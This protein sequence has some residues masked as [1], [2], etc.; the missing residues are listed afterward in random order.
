MWLLQGWGSET[1]TWPCP[2]VVPSLDTGK[3]SGRGWRRGMLWKDDRRADLT[4]PARDGAPPAE[5]GWEGRRTHAPHGTALPRG[6]ALANLISQFSLAL[7]LFLY[8]FWKKL[9]QATWGGK[10]CLLF[11][12]SDMGFASGE[13]QAT[14]SCV[15]MV[16]VPPQAG[17]WSACRTGAPSSAWPSPACSCCAWSG[18]PTRS[19]AS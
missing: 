11:S 7:L 6:S 9:H 12:N 15:V 5:G 13:L 2:R 4:I 10:G 17:P 3:L 1:F 18:G 14:P 19:G 8:I 16:C